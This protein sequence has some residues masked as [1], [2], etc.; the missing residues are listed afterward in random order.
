MKILAIGDM[1]IDE[2]NRLDDLKKILAQ[3]VFIASTRDIDKILFLGDMFTSRRP[4]ALEYRTAYEFVMALRAAITKKTSR[5]IVLLKGNHDVQRD[6]S[7]L[8][9]FDILDV[10]CVKVVESG[11]VEDGIFLGHFILREAVMGPSNFQVE[12]AVT[13]EQ[14]FA[15]FPSHGL[16]LFGDI[17]T[18]QQVNEEPPV[19]YI[20]SIMRNNFGERLNNPRV[21][22]I[23]DGL[24]KESVLLKDRPMF[25]FDAEVTASGLVW[26]GMPPSALDLGGAI[27]KVILHLKESDKSSDY[28]QVL[29]DSLKGASSLLVQ[30]DVIR[31]APVR[32]NAVT[33]EM[34]DFKALEEYLVGKRVEIPVKESAEALN[35]GTAIINK[36]RGT[37]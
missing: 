11:H 9:A 29:R 8:D 37:A 1:H 27:V 6:A 30:Y 20:G 25:Q 4:T 22:L 17:H 16:Y 7:T 35:I 14:L 26:K 31:I 2:G 23:E 21:L 12:G 3:I 18:P 10:P 32:E 19:Y 36:V 5:G 15:R 24:V 34:C 28:D 13:L 33:G